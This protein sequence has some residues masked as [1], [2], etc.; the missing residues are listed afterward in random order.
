MSHAERTEQILQIQRTVPEPTKSTKEHGMVRSR[1]LHYLFFALPMQWEEDYTLENAPLRRGLSQL[2]MCTQHLESGGTLLCR[3]I[4]VETNRKYIL[5]VA[6]FLGLFGDHPR[7][8]RKEYPSSTLM[9]PEL[10]KVY[11]ELARWG[12]KSPPPTRALYP[13]N[14]RRHARKFRLLWPWTRLHASRTR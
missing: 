4:K 5:S 7:D 2:A 10:T 8:Y 6:R 14:A 12:E 1:R 9:A 3:P 11:T 13:G